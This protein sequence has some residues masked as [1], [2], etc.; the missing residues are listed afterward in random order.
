MTTAETTPVEP[1]EGGSRAA[2]TIVLAIGLAAAGGV[3]YAVPETGYYVA[4]LLTAAGARK[5]RSWRSG[6]H[7]SDAATE[8][9]PMDELDMS[10][11]LRRLV[12]DDKGVLL[13]RLRDDLGLPDTRTVRNLLDAEDIAVRAGVRTRAGNG[14]G[15]HRDDI[16]T[17]SPTP[18][19]APSE[20][21]CCSSQPP[22]PTPTTPGEGLR[23]EA[24][25]QAG[26][27]LRT[28]ADAARHH[29]IGR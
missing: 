21:C 29:T 22:T 19:E 16:P 14:P 25:G 2:G 27:V 9:A 3:V 13:T 17:P 24:I 1:L 7:E 12:G 11:A 26:T 5:A 10:E 8:P 18:A 4:G 20:A 28:P 6:R 15:V 23:V